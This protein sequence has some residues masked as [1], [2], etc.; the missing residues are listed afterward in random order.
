M[1]CSKCK[2][3]C[4]YTLNG[5]CVDC[6]AEVWGEIVGRV[7]SECDEIDK[8]IRGNMST[9]D[10][11]TN[12]ITDTTIGTDSVSCTVVTYYNCNKIQCPKC[13]KGYQQNTLG[14]WVVCPICGGTGWIEQ[15]RQREPCPQ[16]EPWYP[17]YNPYPQPY[18][19]NFYGW[20]HWE[21]TTSC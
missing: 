11:T 4:P 19:P 21:Y 12:K 10:T 6:T 8:N 20:T 15:K 2:E 7:S 14:I 16:H 1:K 5:V 13:D 9:T 3:D 17:P 18:V